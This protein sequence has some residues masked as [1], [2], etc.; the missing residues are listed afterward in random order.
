MCDLLYNHVCAVAILSRCYQFARASM[1]PTNQSGR[2]TQSAAPL[3]LCTQCAPVNN[4]VCASQYPTTQA[5]Q[6]GGGFAYDLA[7]YLPTSG[8]ATWSTIPNGIQYKIQDGTVCSSLLPAGQRVLTVQY[9][10]LSTAT[11]PTTFTVN[12][13]STCNYLITIQTSLVC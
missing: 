2:C 8:F 12:E 1:C 11:H 5:C 4:S 9:K 6:V 13:T 3:V 10:C 7:E